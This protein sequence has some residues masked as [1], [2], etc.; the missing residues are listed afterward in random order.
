M[1]VQQSVTRLAIVAVMIAVIA[2]LT[3]A[4]Q[5]PVAATGGY[6][7]FGDVGVFFSAMA[8]GPWIGGITGG[9]GCAIADI[10]TGYASWAPLTL[11]AHGLQGLV[12]G[13][14]ARRQGI[15]GLI[16]AWA[17][18]AVALVLTYFLGEWFIYGLGYGGALAEILPNSLQMLVGGV[19]GLPL[20]LAVRRAYPPLDLIGR[21]KTWTEG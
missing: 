21:G 20:Y 11:L 9:V 19:I 15:A 12:T 3:F 8:F 5:I 1:N 16:A 18:G 10:I 17:G 7:H 13:A 14:L 4:V 6:I 2:V